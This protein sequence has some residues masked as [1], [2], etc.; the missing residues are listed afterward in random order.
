VHFIPNIIPNTLYENNKYSFYCIDKIY[1][2]Y[3]DCFSV[4]Y[5][6]SDLS[7]AGTLNN[8]SGDFIVIVKKPMLMGF[9]VIWTVIAYL[10]EPILSI[11]VLMISIAILDM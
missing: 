6:L 10:I 7:R 4:G 5:F 8:N 11:V 2:L 3:D 1:F 9:A